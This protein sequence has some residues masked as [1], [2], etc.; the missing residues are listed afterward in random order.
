[1]AIEKREFEVTKEID[2]VL[3][4]AVELIKIIKEKGNYLDLMDEFV[5]AIDGVTEISSELK[6]TKALIVTAA[7]R[8]ADLVEI[9]K[10]A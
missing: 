2:D 8:T 3:I 6:N 7:A 1:M 10:K 9:F 5:A 4:L